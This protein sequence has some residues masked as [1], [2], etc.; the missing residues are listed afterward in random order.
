MRKQET[1]RLW[2]FLAFAFGLAWI[3]FLKMFLMGYQWNGDHPYMESF[4]GLGMLAPLAAHFITR[5]ITGEGHK[6]Y[7]K[8]S[9]MLGISF[10]NK[11][12]IYFVLA[13]LLPWICTELSGLLIIITVPGSFDP[14]YYKTLEIDK[15]LLFF[16]PYI[17]SSNACIFSVA[18]L[19]EEVGWRGYMM[20]KLMGLI[21]KKKAVFVG[22]IIWGLWHAPLTCIGHN[23]GSDYPGFPYVGILLM[24]VM[25][26]SMGIVLTFITV[27]T[28]SVW[29]AALMH[30]VYN[31][32][33][34]VLYAMI[35]GEVLE[36]HA[37]A[38]MMVRIETFAPIVLMAVV[39]YI[40]LC[41]DGQKA[42]S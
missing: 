12:W 34:S 32:H 28:D 18:A 38:M 23:F 20:P 8:E 24:C 21:G 10:R 3:L 40:L 42:K 39:F 19:G 16:L 27:K 37:G 25:C 7:G 11:R 22:G 1:K 4:V 31:A 41:R 9:M 30:A 33:P 26:I 36:A 5:K 35:N 29:P 17:S 14:S 2:I 15:R 13:I 6:L